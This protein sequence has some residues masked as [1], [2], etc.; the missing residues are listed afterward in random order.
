MTED[1]FEDELRGLTPE[2]AV[3]ARAVLDELADARR[4]AAMI[5]G[6]VVGLLA[7]LGRL[8]DAQASSSG[9]RAREDARRSFAAQAGIALHTGPA[10]ARARL[11]MA[12]QIH[13]DCP[14]T[15]AA[16][17]EGRLSLR[18]AEQVVK[19]GL[20]LD[21]GARASLDHGAVLLGEQRTARQLG[22]VLQKQAADL[23]ARSFREQHADARAHR[24]VTIRDVGAGMSELLLCG[25]TVEV[26]S[27]FDRVDQM[28]REIKKD[29]ARARRAYEREHGRLPEEGWAAPV[30]GGLDG[31]DP[32]IVAASDLRTLPQVRT[33]LLLDLL[34]TAEPS[35]HELFASGTG[36]GLGE[37]RAGVQVTIPVTQ[38]IG[39]D[40]GAAW[41]DD[42]TLIDADS[43][44]ILAGNTA[45]W[46]R[47]FTRPDMGTIAAV[48][49]Y[50]PTTQQRRAVLARDMTC[51]MPGCE[52]PGRSCDIDHGHDYARGGPTRIDNLEALCP[53]HHQMKHQAGWGVT[54][55]AGGVIV[56]T[57]PTGH[58]VTDEPISRVFFHA[59][60]GVARAEREQ[61][62]REHRAS[63]QRR[64]AGDRAEIHAAGLWGQISKPLQ[65][66]R[67][68]GTGVADEVA[69]SVRLHV[70]PDGELV[71]TC[72]ARI[73]PDEF[74]DM[75]TDGRVTDPQADTWMHC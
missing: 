3:E 75:L 11:A 39:S 23:D 28:A 55:A 20:P 9:S 64:W 26:R 17:Q 38:L 45:G 22:K 35:G 41:L 32:G 12:E 66:V 53:A 65:R 59:T 62:S 15:L 5:E 40:E 2:Q 31:T 68:A 48:D 50:R 47:I 54:Q 19:A 57:T 61:I 36:A 71:E 6:H 30:S 46:E 37:I 21:A 51:R 60:S 52:V 63:D 74:L 10:E 43:A 8:S 29:R 72:Q 7:R 16:L 42:G 1:E 24:H 58:T 70:G 67:D 25:P 69:A 73:D 27:V 49:H 18:H 44:R 4:A 56:F 13:D 14:A 33:D 34:L